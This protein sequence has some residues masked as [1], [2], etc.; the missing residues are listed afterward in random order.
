MYAFFWVILMHSGTTVTTSHTFENQNDVSKKI[1]I[2]RALRIEIHIPWLLWHQANRGETI[3]LDQ[4]AIYAAV[5]CKL[6]KIQVTHI[7]TGNINNLESE[8]E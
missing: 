7:G 1:S 8:N 3:A 6:H 4:N 5:F 2:K